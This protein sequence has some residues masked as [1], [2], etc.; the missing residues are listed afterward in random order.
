MY[1][2][3]PIKHLPSIIEVANISRNNTWRC[4]DKR[5]IFVYINDGSCI[6]VINGR[7]RTLTK[8]QLLIIP[9]GQ[10]YVRKALND[11][12]CQLTYIHFTTQEPIIPI[13][14][15]ELTEQLEEIIANVEDQ[16]A[17]P[18]FM[19]GEAE[20]YVF[21]SQTVSFSPERLSKMTGLID[22]IYSEY[23][24]N[25]NYNRL[26]M[27]LRLMELIAQIGRNTVSEFHKKELFRG[28]KYPH[29]LQKALIFINRNYNRRITVE[30][31]S[32]YCNVSHQYLTR[33]FQKYIRMSPIR[34]INKNK[35]F[36]AIEMLRTTEMSIK[37]IA[38]ELGFDDPNYFSRIFKKE[39][40][41][42][43][44][45][46]RRRIRNYHKDKRPSPATE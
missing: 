4:A 42:S 15:S 45:E 30:E 16:I 7:E 40:K 13:T 10:A 21:M 18:S 17:L 12:M 24:K 32:G 46:T 37:E 36:H 3:I 41:M 14:D 38:Y 39:E 2:R 6:F 11:S 44:I 31:L 9:A 34:Y 35:I 28:E 8:G 25:K 22:D 5:N 26:L 20:P 23:Y 43:P 29:P 33:L 1:Y 27:S 19:E